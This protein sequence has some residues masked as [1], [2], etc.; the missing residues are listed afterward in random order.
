[1]KFEIRR[2][3]NG[4]VLRVE[5]DGAEDGEEVVY[6]ETESDE[7]EAFADFLRHL[8]EHYGPT[9]SRYSPKR[10]CI[11]VEP[12]DKYQPPK[13]AVGVNQKLRIAGG[14]RGHAPHRLPDGKSGT[15]VRYGHRLRAGRDRD[16]GQRGD[17]RVRD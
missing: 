7:I 3:R 15:G 11:L 4:A 10:I 8:L 17:D 9:T 12:G 14:G 6:Q 13:Q 1:M 5:A 2:V 16:H